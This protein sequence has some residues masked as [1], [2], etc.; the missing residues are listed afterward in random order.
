MKAFDKIQNVWLGYASD[1]YIRA[2]GSSGGCVRAILC[3]MLGAGLIDGAVVNV[4]DPNHPGRGMSILAKTQEEVLNC[5]KSIYCIT[6]IKKSVHEAFITTDVK[7]VAVVGLPCQIADLQKMLI[8][9]Q[10]LQ[11]KI[12]ATIGLFCGHNI[13]P[14]ALSEVYT[15]LGMDSKD[16]QSFIYRGSGWYPSKIRITKKDGSIL[17]IPF[18]DSY[19]CKIWRA[20]THVPKMCKECSDFLAESAD[21]SFGDAWL[22]ELYSNQEGYNLGVSFT[23]VGTDLMQKCMS[24]GV[25]DLKKGD[26]S[27]L[28]KSNGEQLRLKEGQRG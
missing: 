14:T 12:V 6:E 24:E 21:I 13:A 3:Y 19:F 17:D 27:L 18:E 28:L 5:A 15:S 9:D 2:K 26:V 25:L 11:S 10:S 16:V 4:E 1:P 22:P 20:F 8:N 7:R 23:K